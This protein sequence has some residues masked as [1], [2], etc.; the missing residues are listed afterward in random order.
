M[1]VTTENQSLCYNCFSRLDSP[2]GACPYCGFDLAENTQKYPV[3]L[4]A[5]TVLNGRYIVGRVLGQG[6][7]GITYLAL[8]TQLNA[9]VAIKEFMPG[10]IATRIGTTVSVMA[11]TKTNDFAYGAE[12]FQEEART[13]A[14]FIGHPNIAG[15]SSYFDENDT[16]YFVMD[17]IEG[18]SFKNY[19]ANA[20]GKVG[21]DEALNVMIPVLRALT[22][23]HAEGFIH[24]DVT[25]DNIYISKDGN[26]KLLDFGSARYSIGDK[27]KSLD[28]ILKVGYAPKEQYI[29]RGRQGP[30]TDVYSCAACLYAA[31]T[32]YLPP[33]SLE[34]LDHDE[35]VPVSQCGVEIPEW[36][37]KAILKGLAVQPENRF[38]SAAEFL[39]AIENQQVVEVAAPPGTEVK[40]EPEDLLTKLK[41]KPAMLA[42]IAAAALALVIGV[43]VLGGGGGGSGGGRNDN[44]YEQNNL[45]NPSS[46]KYIKPEVASVTIQGQEY[47][48]D[49]YR[50][51]LESAGLSD[52]DIQD[53]KYM[54]NL[55]RLNLNG[56]NISDLSFAEDLPMLSDLRLE[57][58]PVSDISPLARL[59]KLEYV[60]LRDT[61]VEDLSPLAGLTN[62]TELDLG[63]AGAA[64]DLSPLASM[65]KLEYLNLPADMLPTDLS[66]LAALVNLKNIS[67]NGSSNDGW[68][69][70]V[71]WLAGM[72]K[73]EQL[74]LPV[75]GLT[76]LR[77]L[78]GATSLETLNIYGSMEISD[79]SP[80][81]G[82]AKLKNLY[83]Q[84][85][86]NSGG[87]ITAKDLSALSG[88]TALEKLTLDC[89]QITS[90]NGLSGLTKLKELRLYAYNGNSA[91]TDLSGLSGLSNLKTLSL[92]TGVM[93]D[94]SP[95]SSL[96]GLQELQ[97][98]GDLYV[99]DLDWASD[100]TSLT[101]FQVSGSESYVN[102]LTPLT[103][104]TKLTELRINTTGLRSFAGLENLTSLTTLSINGSDAVYTDLTPLAGLTKLES[105]SLPSRNYQYDEANPCDISGLA[106]MTKLKDLN[107]YQNIKD[108]SPLANLTGLQSLYIKIGVHNT[109]LTPLSSL[110]GLKTLTLSE[111]S[112]DYYDRNK[113]YPSL[114]SL[115]SLTGLT[116]LQLNS[117]RVVDI[118]PLSGLTGLR[119]LTLYTYNYDHP[120]T[121]L[122]P[123][124][125]LTNLSSLTVSGSQYISDWSPVEHV[126]SVSKN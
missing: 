106:G 15:V 13:L 107:F 11:E 17:Y 3:A 108:L 25:P 125:S 98:Y 26:V 47:S 34:R 45:R 104:L 109:D 115:A 79:L 91:L 8:D 96:T 14:K 53:L 27:S 92:Y 31:L 55:S 87:G 84:G 44:Y 46:E 97:I 2:E 88:L 117:S 30:F 100:L 90:L 80:L 54:V 95:L 28:V 7:F 78:E 58:N 67:F 77:G 43:G 4:R 52:A 51:E 35:L 20:G 63:G 124:R 56:N 81:S 94:L 103:N 89:G 116:E 113:S 9:R 119:T 123:L 83:I 5:G 12:R 76:S 72:S 112:V 102:D 121:S 61:P 1:P 40:T 39:E 66:P 41:K 74:Y 82:L 85:S 114:Q 16:S 21:V 73:L 23:V 60:C 19:I 105:L 24:R 10:E 126:A 69:S 59:T 22:A 64:L 57:G 62:L 111:G 49:L 99:H 110:T 70:D 71:S 93:E 122:E 6:G 36:L 42:G 32:G 120:I 68:I 65:T 50:L 86:G 101:S 75:S 118:S 38:Q 48:T 37:D 29:R 33:E 18:I